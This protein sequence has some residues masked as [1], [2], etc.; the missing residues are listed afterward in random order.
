MNSLSEV[1]LALFLLT[2]FWMAGASRLMH[3]IRLASYQG[4]IIGLFPL[5]M[6]H[7]HDST[8]GVGVF[9][10]AA[11]TLGVKGVLLPWFLRRAMFRASVR[12][13]LEPLVGY[14]SSLLIVLAA[15]AGAFYVCEKFGIG[16]P[17]APML[18]APGAFTAMFTGLFIIMARRKA[19]TQ[20]IGFL[21]FENGITV[22]GI[23]MMLEYGMLVEL[24]ILLDVFVLIFVMGIA[25]FHISREL[26][27][28]DA[29]RLHLLRDDRKKEELV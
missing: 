15:A 7:W 6:W 9:V 8:P 5:A 26:S 2:D 14:P 13:E 20:A 27:H 16:S 23:G 12:R 24:G 10:I 17:G 3:C 18:A 29:D 22:F 11:V 28:I 21:V 19:I 4:I 1:L 25:V